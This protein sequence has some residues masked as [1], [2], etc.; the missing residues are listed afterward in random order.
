MDDLRARKNMPRS[1]IANAGTFASIENRKLTLPV[2]SSPPFI[3][4]QYGALL[5]FYPSQTVV[6][7]IY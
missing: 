5:K 4:S 3:L 1:P 7:I 6:S 2:N